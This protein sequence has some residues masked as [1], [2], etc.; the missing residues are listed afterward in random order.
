MEHAWVQSATQKKAVKYWVQAAKLSIGCLLETRVQED[1]FQ[2]VFDAAFPGWNC[3]HNYSHHRLGRIWVCWSEEVEVCP[4]LTSSQ[5]ITVW[6]RYKSMGDTFLCSFIY[7][8]N[9]PIERRE[10]WRE[11]EFISESVAGTTNPWIIQGDFNAA[12]T[13][14]EHSRFTDTRSDRSSIR[15]FQNVVLSCDMVDLAQVG[16]CYTW[17][18][19]QDDNPISKKLDRVMVNSFWLQ[20]FPQSYAT[21]ESGGVSDHLR[22]HVLLREA[23]QG[24]M[25]PF[26]FFTHTT[27]HPRFLEVVDR[28]W[29]QTAPL[30][31]SRSALQLF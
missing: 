14:Q 4:V 23:P 13:K 22:I 30:Y 31:H 1:K 6:W 27:S 26:K 9:C 21:F 19:S 10:L 29:N 17:S 11:M 25:K 18:N 24:N 3:I 16:P 12:L 5:M 15:D 8:S 2:K 28:I 20:A 7:A